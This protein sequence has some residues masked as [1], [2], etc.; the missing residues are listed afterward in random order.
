MITSFNET[1]V[2]QFRLEV[3]TALR[4]IA[5]RHGLKAS[6]LGS[7]GYNA[8]TLHTAKLSFAIAS[9]Q[10]PTDAPLESFIGKRFKQGSR[11][12]TIY[13]VEGGKLVGRTNRGASYTI[14]RDS[15]SSMIQLK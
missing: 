3:E 7:I 2:K 5:E 9:S 4:Q 12:F 11:T 15:L 1:N 8:S 14:S 10:L 13:K 6:S